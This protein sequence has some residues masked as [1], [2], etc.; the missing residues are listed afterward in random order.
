MEE[1]VAPMVKCLL[2]HLALNLYLFP[3]NRTLSLGPRVP[4]RGGFGAV[5]PRDGSELSS[6]PHLRQ[7][8]ESVKIETCCGSTPAFRGWQEGTCGGFIFSLFQS[9]PGCID[10]TR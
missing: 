5:C 6:E 4:R 3:D 1:V 8:T 10:L 7:N 9:V 2:S